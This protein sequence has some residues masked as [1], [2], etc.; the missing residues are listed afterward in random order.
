MEFFCCVL[1]VASLRSFAELFQKRQ[2]NVGTGVLDGPYFYGKI[3]RKRGARPYGFGVKLQSFFVGTGVLDGPYFYGKISRTSGARPYE[4]GCEA[5]IF[6]CRDRRPR[7]SEDISA[8]TNFNSVFP[9][10]RLLYCRDRRPRRSKNL[11][12]RSK[13]LTC[14]ISV[15]F[16][17]II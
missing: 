2:Y 11:S 14:F 9:T 17:L 8:P 12:Q 6:L 7:R 13:A 1:R 10:I 4:F 15:N 5:S 16:K 3:S